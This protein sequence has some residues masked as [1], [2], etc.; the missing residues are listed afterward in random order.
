AGDYFMEGYFLKSTVNPNG[1]KDE[2]Y[3]SARG[4]EAPADKAEHP[5]FA[6]S[7]IDTALYWNTFFFKGYSGYFLQADQSYIHFPGVAVRC[8]GE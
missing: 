5:I 6:T 4:Y 1:K 7:S 3:Y 8:T 2:F